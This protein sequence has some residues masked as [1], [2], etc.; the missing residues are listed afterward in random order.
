[1]FRPALGLDGVKRQA[2]IRLIARR[3]ARRHFEAPAQ[4][5]PCQRRPFTAGVAKTIFL[6]GGD[7][8]RYANYLCGMALLIPL[9]ANLTPTA[10]NFTGVVS[11]QAGRLSEVTIV[12]QHWELDPTSKRERPV[13]NPTITTDGNGRFAAYLPPGLYDVMFSHV[14][15][16]PTATKVKIEPIG[17]TTLDCQ[18][19]LS[20]LAPTAGPLKIGSTMAPSS[21]PPRATSSCLE[22][23]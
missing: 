8:R 9:L 20:S 5:N 23:P 15:M 21:P 6:L 4:D 18:L 14:V 13:Q 16:E 11:D 22:R 17:S 10:P 12:V 2:A 1:M 3:E 19:Q 7:M